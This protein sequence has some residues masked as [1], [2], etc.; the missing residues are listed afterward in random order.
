MG[1]HRFLRTPLSAW[2]QLCLKL[3]LPLDF[4]AVRADKFPSRL[5]PFDLGFCHLKSGVLPVVLHAQ[6]SPLL[7]PQPVFTALAPE[8]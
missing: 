4:L 5:S 3:Y 7:S 2:I 6:A 1:T 8:P